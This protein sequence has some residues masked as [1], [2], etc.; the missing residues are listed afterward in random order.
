M[1]SAKKHQENVLTK[2][3]INNNISKGVNANYVGVQSR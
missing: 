3:I 2:N 1:G